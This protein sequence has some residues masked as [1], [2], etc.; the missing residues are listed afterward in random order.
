MTTPL[1]G[2]P[3]S[4]FIEKKVA[5]IHIPKTAGIY[6][7]TYLQTNLKKNGYKVHQL[8]ATDSPRFKDPHRGGDWNEEELLEIARCSEPAQFVSNHSPSWTPRA[9]REFKKMGWLTFAFVRHPGDQLCSLYFFSRERYNLYVNTPLDHYVQVLLKDKTD[10]CWYLPEFWEEIDYI[11]EYTEKNFRNFLN[12][13]LGHVYSPGPKLNTSVNKGYEH[14]CETGEISPSTAKL[15]KD[16]EQYRL[17]MKI[18][19]QG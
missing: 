4:P 14:Y 7:E 12:S 17:Y 5:F 6:V 9:F 1:D 11:R 3:S 2:T 13:H 18:R 16:N 8:K 15:V 10:R 19:A